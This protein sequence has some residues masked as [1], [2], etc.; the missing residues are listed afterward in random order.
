MDRKLRGACDCQGPSTLGP[1]WQ[2]RQ[3]PTRKIL[4]PAERCLRHLRASSRE[5]GPWGFSGRITGWWLG[6]VTLVT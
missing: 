1:G 5:R 6:L 3:E 2:S 4:E